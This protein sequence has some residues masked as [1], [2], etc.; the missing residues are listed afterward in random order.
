MENQLCFRCFKM[1]GSY[2]VCPHCGYEEDTGAAQAY[3]LA[4]GTVL[5][6]RYIIGVSIGFGGFGITYKAFDT[7][8]SIVVAIKE[9]YPAGL[10]NRGEGEVKVGIFSGEKEKEFKRQLERFLEEARNMAI[11]SKEKD[12]INVFDYFEENQT[13]YIIMEYVDAPLL[14]ESLKEKGKF[15]AKEAE[16]YILALLEALSKVHYHGIIH[17][18]VSPDNIFLLGEDSIKLFDFGAAKFQGTETE[19]TEDVVVK[20]GYTPPEQ[21]RSRNAQGAFMDIYAVGAV[22]YE[23]VTGEKPMEAPDRSVGDELKKPGEFEIEIEERLER[24]ILKALALKPELRFQTAEQ[25]KEAITGRKKVGLPEEELRKYQKKKKAFAVGLVSVFTVLGSIFLLSQTYFSGRGKIDV[26]KIR[27]EDMEVWISSE[28]ADT[29]KELSEVFLESVEKECPKL[30][31]TV[32]VVN[33][34]EYGARLQQAAEKGKLPDVFCTEG[35]EAAE[36]CTD[37]SRLLNTMELSSYLCLGELGKKAYELPTAMQIAVAYISEEKEADLPEF[38]DADSL[39]DQKDILEY[40]ETEEAF[41]AFQDKNSPV[42]RIAGDLS[43]MDRV[44]EV[45]VD[46]IP[47]TD[48][49]VLPILKD[50]KL[51][52]TLEHPYGVSKYGDSS[53]QEAG[54]FLLSL[55]FSDGMQSAAYMGNEEGIPLNRRVFAN[56]EENKMTTYL[57]FLKEYDLESAELYG[58]GGICQILQEEAARNSK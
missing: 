30:H 58:D 36:Y 7:V 12:I 40:A 13:A 53:R 35:I 15:P 47:P 44:K 43:D 2:G 16:K 37:L 28:D 4:P 49:S 21:Y 19:R 26:S 1:K 45:T 23:M 24:I 11:F 10:V 32:R 27:E 34:E 51:V 39:S 20:A 54:M 6:G 29:G 18:D 3:Q 33:R 52:G 22:F 42:S 50:G 25:M 5:R 41:L 46:V 38:L 55:L 56:Y 14:K 8:L 9:F 17:K 57:D 48:F 31:V